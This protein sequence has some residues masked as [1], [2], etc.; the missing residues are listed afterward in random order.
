MKVTLSVLLLREL[1]LLDRIKPK[2]P[3]LPPSQ[4]ISGFKDS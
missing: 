2:R 1:R 3:K 4:G